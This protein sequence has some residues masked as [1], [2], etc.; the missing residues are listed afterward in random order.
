MQMLTDIK[1]RSEKAVGGKEKKI[2]DGF[3]LYL[4]VKPRGT[5]LW[6]MAYRFN[7][8]QKKLSFGIYGSDDEGRVSLATARKKRDEA[9]ALIAKGIDPGIARKEERLEKAT[10]RPFASWADEWLA[11]QEAECCERTMNGK[12]RFVGYLKDQFGSSMIGDIGVESV[13]AYLKTLQNE[14]K[15]ETRDRVRA[16]GEDICKFADL[17]RTRHNPF[18]DLGDFLIQNVS[19]R[20]PAI[21][22]PINAVAQLFQDIAASLDNSRFGDL[23]GHALRFLSLTAVRPG[24]VN[25]S[26][27]AEI[28]SEKGRWTISATKMKMD[29]DHVVPLSRQ[30]LEILKAVHELTGNRRYIFSCT[31]D[32][33]LSNN[34]LNKRLRVIGY[35]TATEHCAHG[36]R[37]TFSTLCHHQV[38]RDDNKLWDSDVVE[39]CLAH[40]DEESVKA[41]YNKMG[42]L[43]LIGPRT[44]LMQHWADRIDAMVDS[45]KVIP[46]NRP[47]RRR[48]RART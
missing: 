24:E 47:I 18:R 40:L 42:P 14:G 13:V 44:K 28:D 19:E 36:F 22:E 34:T 4:L 2:S 3:G 39:L 6:Q 11:K 38:D 10:A 7:G 43:A 33:P 25:N 46:I 27:W 31:N 12:R 15:L 1:C 17:K 41:I 37:S 5:K 30:A 23:V 32:Q 45:D 26:E 20:R 9:K 21:T 48:H 35:D 29:K 16:A 8:R